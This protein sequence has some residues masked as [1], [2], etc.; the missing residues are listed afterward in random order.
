MLL[1]NDL[2]IDCKIFSDGQMLV[3]LPTEIEGDRV[4]LTWK[5]SHAAEITLLI[6]VRNA[7][8]NMG[9]VDVDLDI[10]YFPGARQDRACQAGQANS[11]QA[12]FTVI[13][14]LGFSV[15]R[16]YD[17][18]NSEPLTHFERKTIIMEIKLS[19]IF[20][21]YP[22]IK[23]YINEKNLVLCAPDKGALE[24][25]EGVRYIHEELGCYMEM[26]KVR[27]KSN[28]IIEGLEISHMGSFHQGDSVLIV[29]DICDGGA[30]F[31]RAAEKLKEY[32][33]GRLYLYVT[34]GIFSKGLEELGKHFEH[35]YCHHVLHDNK[36]SSGAGLT[37]LREFPDAQESAIS[38]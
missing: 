14:N 21:R 27:N 35:I 28:G 1:L 33:A 9:F 19:S 23:K 24:R 3:N 13:D 34:H 7:L 38:H 37:I 5:P 32:G 10:L 36:F 4:I 30:T 6:E 26:S 2:P 8:E 22:I 29:D 11:F 16:L 25:V 20:A 17:I 31:I 15:I 18:H 12:L